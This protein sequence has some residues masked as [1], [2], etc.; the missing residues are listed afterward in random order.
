MRMGGHLNLLEFSKDELIQTEKI[1]EEQ[2]FTRRDAPMWRL[3]GSLEQVDIYQEI[4]YPLRTKTVPHRDRAGGQVTP[5]PP[6][7]NRFGGGELL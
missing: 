5:P 7:K 6:N 4:L 3:Y 1:L 2:V